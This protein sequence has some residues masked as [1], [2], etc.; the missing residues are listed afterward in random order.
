MSYV[1]RKNTQVEG[2]AAVLS[3]V[4]RRLGVAL[5][6]LLMATL[7]MLGA[8]FGQPVV[9][10]L[11][12]NELRVTA[13]AEGA[14]CGSHLEWSFEQ[15]EISPGTRVT[16]VNDT[17]YWRIPVVVE[18]LQSD[19][20]WS[21]V[22]ESPGLLNGESWTQTLWRTGDYRIISADATQRLA[23]LETVISVK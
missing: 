19:G 17:V 15:A 11:G 8:Y 9:Q 7:G 14:G 18:R 16:V 21:A 2:L 13:Q 1:A 12:G 22:A 6:V 3:R 20:Q 23:G 10:Y 4:E 5:A